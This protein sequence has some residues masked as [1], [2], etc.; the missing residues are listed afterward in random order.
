[1][2]TT[3]CRPFCIDYK[4]AFDL[5]FSD[6]VLLIFLCFSSFSMVEE[7]D[8]FRQFRDFDFASLDSYQ[9]T[10][11][12]VLLQYLVGLS[13]KELEVREEISKGVMNTKRIPPEDLAQLVLQTKCFM[14]C[15]ATDQL[16]DLQAYNVW[17]E[18][19][20]VDGP[21]TSYEQIVN[22]IVN[23]EPVPGIKQ[24]PDTV[25]NPDDAEESKLDARKKPWEQ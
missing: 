1:M 25:L 4:C 15:Q 22:L 12:Q 18:N 23:N 6:F 24:I 10:L 19:E 14:F 5:D 11:D 21:T 3:N 9:Q 2:E 7:V 16:L 20:I 17:L 8:L 13:E